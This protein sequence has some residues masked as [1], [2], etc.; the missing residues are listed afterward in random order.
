[1]R[2][3]A[4]WLLAMALAAALPFAMLAM[5]EA[6][7]VV[8]AKVQGKPAAGARAAQT[9]EVPRRIVSLN[10]CIDAILLEVADPAQIR[11]LSHYSHDSAQSSASEAARRFPVTYATAEEILLLKPD[12]VLASMHSSPATRRAME[13]MDIPVASFGVPATVAESHAQIREVAARVGHPER[14]EALIRR[15]DKALEALRPKTNGPLVPTLILQPGGF[16]PGLGTLQDDLLALAG[17]RNASAQYGVDF[18]GVVPLEAL[19]ANPPRLLLIGEEATPSSDGGD[20][21]LSH[22]VLRRLEGRMVTSPYP[23]HLL[24]CGGPTLLEAAR[25]LRLARNALDNAS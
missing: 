7:E 21:L 14:G 2:R 3:R 16:S 1:M 12:L 10:P 19:V 25:Y 11:A 8:A 20:R 24:Y 6:R 22:P 23:R 17:L 5:T 9:A 15:I 18:W 13:K 4:P